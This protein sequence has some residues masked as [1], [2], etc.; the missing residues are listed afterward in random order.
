MRRPIV[1]WHDPNFGVRFNDYMTAIEDVVPKGRMR[2][3]AESSLS[4]L[5]EPNLKRMQRNGFV[6]ILPGIEILVRARQQVEDR[7]VGRHGQGAPGRRA[8]EPDPAPHS[9]GADQFRAGPRLRFRRRA[10]RAH[11]ALPRSRARR[12]SGLLAADL[13]MAPRR[14]SISS[15]SGPGGCCPSRTISWT[16]ITR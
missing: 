2:F 9:H 16:A 13:P 8:R 15:S 3:I 1:A 11:Q 7:Q 4:L 14:R 6:G 10:V 5:S 12:L